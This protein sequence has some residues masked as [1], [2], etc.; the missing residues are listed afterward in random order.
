MPT[1]VAVGALIESESGPVN[2]GLDAGETVT[3]RFFLR[4]TGGS[5][6]A[7]LTGT[8]AASGGVVSPSS[9]QSYGAVPFGG[10]PV[11]RSYSFSASGSP[12]GTVTA[13]LWLTNGG[14]RATQA[15]ES[16]RASNGERT[17]SACATEQRLA[18]AGDLCAVC[19]GAGLV[20]QRA[21]L[22]TTCRRGWIQKI[23]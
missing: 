11:G 8:L 17:P 23:G 10:A 1:I 12:G 20:E 2:G 3:I 9:A 16:G 15:V 5:D 21:W 7:G 4:N 18:V 13:T 6:V 14:Q 19:A 22:S